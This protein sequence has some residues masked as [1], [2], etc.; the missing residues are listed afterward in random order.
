MK[1]RFD[2]TDLRL[3]IEVADTGSITAGAARSHIA[4]ASASVRIRDLEDDLGTSL[5]TRGRQGVSLTPAGEI[6]LRHARIVMRQ[7]QHLG[8]ELRQHGEGMEGH[9]RLMCNTAA[10]A[11]LLFD[12]VRVFLAENPGVSIDVK[13]RSSR[14]IVDA[15][16]A[17]EADIGVVSDSIDVAGLEALSLG[18]VRLRLVTSTKHPLADRKS[19]SFVEALEHDFVGVQEG[20]A[21]DELLTRMAARA[22]KRLIYRARLADHEEV[23]RMIESGVGIGVLPARIYERYRKAMSLGAVD[24]T[25]AWAL[26][27]LTLCVRRADHL[28]VHAR[29]LIDAMRA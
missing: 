11:E 3:F 22:G 23:C 2:L 16:T 19:V 7:L 27:R 26:R 25:D 24:L 28:P 13:E 21:M 20:A 29:K 17:G 4:T 8:D 15:V 5:F 9:V 1:I 6:L 14:E 18:S 10:L 12:A